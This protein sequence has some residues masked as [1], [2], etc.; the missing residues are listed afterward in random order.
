MDVYF[1]NT[2]DEA[3]PP[4]P[5]TAVP[6]EGESS[7]V[8]AEGRVDLDSPLI[9]QNDADIGNL[10]TAVSELMYDAGFSIVSAETGSGA[11][12][13]TVIYDYAESPETAQYVAAQ[14][15]LDESAIVYSNGGNGIII[16]VGSDLAWIL[17]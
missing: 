2:S 9:V 6:P 13:E 15:G 12:S 7:P 4:T 10:A 8:V 11:Q 1:N 3:P 5:T 17:E 14:L 16:E